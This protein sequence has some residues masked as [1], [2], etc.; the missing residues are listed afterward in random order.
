MT[1]GCLCGA[2]RFE[3]T[4]PP[5]WA[6]MLGIAAAGAAAMSA[7]AVARRIARTS[8]TTRAGGESGGQRGFAS[9]YRSRPSSGIGSHA[10]A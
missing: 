2:V 5:R 1:G 4:E 3:L 10:G 6:W 7:I 9:G 8:S